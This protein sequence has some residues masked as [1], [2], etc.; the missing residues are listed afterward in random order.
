MF[1]TNNM[2]RLRLVVW[3][4]ALQFCKR[5]YFCMFLNEN[6]RWAKGNGLYYNIAED[7]EQFL[8]R[9]ETVLRGIWVKIGV[10]C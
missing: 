1:R 8:L 6:M 5:M 4:L 2:A 10:D 3:A 7:F 9:F